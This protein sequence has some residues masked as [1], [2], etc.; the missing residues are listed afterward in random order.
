MGW[1][2]SRSAY[3]AAQDDGREVAEAVRGLEVRLERM[4]AQNAKLMALLEARL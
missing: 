4:E 3:G 1:R 2:Q